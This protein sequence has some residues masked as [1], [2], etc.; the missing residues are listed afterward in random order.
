MNCFTECLYLELKTAGSRVRM[1]S[2]CPGFTYT[3][4]HDVLGIDRNFI[5]KAWWMPAEEVVTASLEGLE[6]GKLFVMPGWRYKLLVAIIRVMPRGVLHFAADPRAL[7]ACGANGS[8]QS[9]SSVVSYQFSVIS[10][11][12]LDGAGKSAGIS[13]AQWLPR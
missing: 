10:R 7:P 3:E 1:Q 13:R 9:E 4:F 8:P 2:L 5:S 12:C 6:K 11:I